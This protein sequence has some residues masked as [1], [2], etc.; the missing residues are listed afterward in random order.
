M[1]WESEGGREGGKDHRIDDNQRNPHW[2]GCDVP[3]I[4]ETV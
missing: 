1:N 2:F 3:M 4:T